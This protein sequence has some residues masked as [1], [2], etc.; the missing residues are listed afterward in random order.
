[1]QGD[2]LTANPDRLSWARW[3][4]RLSLGSSLPTWQPNLGGAEAMGLKVDSVSLVGDYYFSR[5]LVGHRSSGGF[6]TT[7][8]LIHGPRSQLTSGRPLLGSQPAGFSVERHLVGAADGAGPDGAADIAT[9][10]YL[11]IGYTGLSLKGGW[12]F[13]ADLG[14]MALSPGNSVKLG[15]VVGGTQSLDDLLREMRLAPVLQLG[16]SYS[17]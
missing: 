5:S 14:M 12:R 6:R 16:V 8:G 10:P 13:N 9:L 15:R 4:G 7:G 11:G 3:Q 1:V 17:F 2:G